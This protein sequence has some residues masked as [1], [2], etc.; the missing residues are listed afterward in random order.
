MDSG[1]NSRR[2][3]YP[4]RVALACNLETAG[5]LPL[6]IQGRLRHGFHFTLKSVL[7]ESAVT[8]L[9]ERVAG[10][11]VSKTKPFAAQGDWLQILIQENF[12]NEFQERIACLDSPYLKLPQT[13]Q[14]HPQLSITV[15]SD[16][17]QV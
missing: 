2:V 6:C 4:R 9:T 5:Y 1:L 12:L 17:H 8:F 11:L 13:I 16:A 14:I 3:T 10:T 7:K 15:F